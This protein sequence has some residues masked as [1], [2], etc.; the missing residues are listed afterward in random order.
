MFQGFVLIWI[1]L[2]KVKVVSYEGSDPWVCGGKD[3]DKI[4]VVIL[5]Y[6]K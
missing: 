5:Y 1:S 3:L 4:W 2:E 6:L